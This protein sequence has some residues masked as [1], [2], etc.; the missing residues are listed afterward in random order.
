MN[1]ERMSQEKV[2]KVPIQTVRYVEE[3]RVRTVKVP[4]C[5]VV[6]QEVVR[7]VPVTTYRVILPPPVPTTV[8]YYDPLVPWTVL[9]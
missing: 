9:P 3:E 6:E 7:Q 8:F 2:R 1:R 4:V 5:R